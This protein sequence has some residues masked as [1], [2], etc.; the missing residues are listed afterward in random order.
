LTKYGPK[1]ICSIAKS[2]TCSPVSS[3]Q[4]KQFDPFCRD[5][6]MFTPCPH[7]IHLREWPC[8][9]TAFLSLDPRDALIMVTDWELCIAFQDAKKI[10]YNLTQSNPWAPHFLWRS[11][12]GWLPQLKHRDYALNGRGCDAGLYLPSLGQR[13]SCP[14]ASAT[15]SFHEHTFRCST[16]HSGSQTSTL[17]IAQI[18]IEKSL[19]KTNINLKLWMYWSIRYVHNFC[20]FIAIPILW[21]GSRGYNQI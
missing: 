10:I 11:G 14:F 1:E 6:E 18:K 15:P 3:L 2:N 19:W 4:A 13:P 17:L 5:L 21:W 9:H 12:R 8:N 7:L 20:I 16:G